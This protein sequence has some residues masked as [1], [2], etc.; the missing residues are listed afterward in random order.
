MSGESFNAALVGAQGEFGKIPKGKVAKAGSFSYSYADLAD[1][2]EQVRPVLAKHGLG[3]VQDVT[4]AD[5]AIHLTTELI[6]V[7]G[8]SRT[9]GPLTLHAGDSP[10]SM[11]SAITY[12]RRYAL[13]AALGIAADDD[14]G[15]AASRPVE[16][17]E[18]GQP[19]GGR[20]AAEK[21]IRGKLLKLPTWELEVVQQ[22]FRERFGMGLS[23][24]PPEQH[25][26]ALLFVEATLAELAEP[27]PPAGDYE[28]GTE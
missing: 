5:G 10:Q 13:M 27:A 7:S 6:H 18:T 25:G 19:A 4:N 28:G 9:F 12:G 14:D 22:A 8:E 11:G 16:K 21:L 1:V 2:L 15:Q 24:L 17:P 23:Q 3:V 26:E 20:T